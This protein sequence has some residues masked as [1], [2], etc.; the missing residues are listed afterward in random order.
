[1]LLLLLM[2]IRFY[3]TAPTTKAAREKT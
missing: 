2:M 1:M 3:L